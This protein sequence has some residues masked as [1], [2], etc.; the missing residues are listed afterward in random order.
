MVN[1]KPQT[2]YRSPKSHPLGVVTQITES[3]SL[4]KRSNKNWFSIPQDRLLDKHKNTN[5]YIKFL[6]RCINVPY[7][8]NNTYESVYKALDNRPDSSQGCHKF[9]FPYTRA[10]NFR[11]ESSSQI[12]QY[13]RQVTEFTVY[14]SA[15]SLILYSEIR[16]LVFTPPTK[17][18]NSKAII[19]KAKCLPPN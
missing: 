6:N 14:V 2:C 8:Q 3:S 7:S 19:V 15:A 18:C 10:R 9:S 16:K 17:N 13:G 4:L 12:R 5:P 11:S 1:L